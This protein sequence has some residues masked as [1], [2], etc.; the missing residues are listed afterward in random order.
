MINGWSVWGGFFVG[1]LLAFGLEAGLLYRQQRS[2]AARVYSLFMLI[3]LLLAAAS[4]IQGQVRLPPERPIVG[5]RW[6][7]ER[8]AVNSYSP[9]PP[10]AIAITRERLPVT[11]L[12][13]NMGEAETS[14]VP[15]GRLTI[16]QLNIN[17][18]I[19]TIPIHQQT[20]DVT[21]LGHNIGWLT[22][23]GTHPGDDLAMVFAG[24]MTFSTDTTLD[25]GAFAELQYATYGTEI[26]YQTADEAVVY[27]VNKISRVP[28]D[29]IEELF[30][31]D[32][33]SILL[34]TCTD[35]QPASRTYENRL[36]VRATRVEV[37]DY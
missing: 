6:L 23:T 15:N 14:V 36:I 5:E 8:T 37:K 7:G 2:V 28:P 10:P 24:H 34:I 17:A 35:W 22:Q 4:F 1:L 12:E 16:P 27:T 31:S 20:W 19:V 3:S 32:G 18:P 29:A 21:Q 26:I 25:Q 13:E 9:L 30:L 33:N 11:E